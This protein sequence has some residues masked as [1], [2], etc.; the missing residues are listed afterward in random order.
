MSDSILIVDDSPSMLMSVEI[1]LGETSLTVHKAES[2]EQAL[3][4]LSGGLK[5]AMILTD[6]NMGSLSGIDL[7]RVAR[8]LPGLSF[9]PIVLLTTESAQDMRNVAK[10][11]G[12][13]GWLTKP[14]EADALLKIV[15]KLV[16]SA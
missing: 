11:A 8:Q 4:L 14:V 10:A 1:M 13:T 12:A 9:T 2:G 3:E 5:P 15:R 6:L 7:V 16:P